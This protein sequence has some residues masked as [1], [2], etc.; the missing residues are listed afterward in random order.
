MKKKIYLNTVTSLLLQVVTVI[1]GFILPRMILGTYGSDVNGLVQSITQFLGVI[2]F[3]ELGVGQ[4]IQSALYK[5]LAKKDTVAVSKVI[6]SGDKFFKRIAYI[7][8]IYVGFLVFVYPLVINNSFDWLYTAMLIVSISISSFAQYYFGVIDRLLLNA[9]QKGY[10]QYI[11]QIVAI[12]ANTIAGVILINAGSSIQT[13]KLTTALIYMVRPLVV[14]W[15]INKNYNIN[16]KIQYDSEPIKQKW[17]GI[18]Q[19]V[20]AFVLGGTD[21]IVLTLFTPLENVSIYS[22]YYLVIYGIRQLFESATAGLHS[23]I[24]NLWAK[25]EIERLHRIYGY[26]EIILHFGT[27]FL[28]TCTIVLLFPFIRVYTDGINDINYIQ[29]VFGILLSLAYAFQCIRTT[30]NMVILAGGDYKQTQNCHIIAAIINLVLSIVM[31]KTYGLVGVAIGTIVAMVY[32]TIW[33]A[34]Y[35]SKNLLKW[36]F[37]NFVKQCILDLITGL[38]IVW[39]TNWIELT[40]VSYFAWFMMAIKVGIIAAIIVIMMAYIFHK[41]KVIEIVHGI[42]NRRK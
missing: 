34:W 10:I 41:Q 30:Y 23:L 5:P 14:R 37:G 6:S 9:D 21:N 20:S 29:P 32:Q 19:H 2:S 28:Y 17:N 27:V 42:L 38:L 11:S 8:V 26:I 16:R 25:K 1:C 31:V 33:M 39:A 15:Y 4:V 36:P 18:A 22:V 13:V 3:L 24:G 35:T 7:L 12:A 40:A